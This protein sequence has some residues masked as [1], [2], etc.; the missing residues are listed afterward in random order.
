M[1]KLF[2]CAILVLAMASQAFAFGGHHGSAPGPGNDV[3]YGGGGFTPDPPAGPT[4]GGGDRPP[5]SVP[6]PATLL[7]LGAG[8][9]GLV[10]LKRKMK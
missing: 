3:V 1:R 10:G 8:L 9:V 2:I 5:V 7:L 4:D 6:E